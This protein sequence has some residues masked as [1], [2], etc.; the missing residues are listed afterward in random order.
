MDFHRSYDMP[1]A[2]AIER[3]RA[4]AD[5][6]IA[7]HGVNITWEGP[8]AHLDGKV[9]GVKFK[10]HVDCAGGTIDAEMKANFLAEKLGGKL[11]V[12]RKLDD[13]LDPKNSVDALRARIPR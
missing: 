6:W 10:G 7:K 9:K 2:E 12:G 3:L 5:Y 8:V 1:E 4:L 11:Y 13:Y